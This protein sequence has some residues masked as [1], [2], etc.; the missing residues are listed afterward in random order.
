M[1]RHFLV[2]MSK[3]VYSEPFGDVPFIS[4]E[5]R[6]AANRKAAGGRGSTEPATRRD[7]QE[8]IAR[9]HKIAVT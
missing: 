9:P 1:L 3:P 4:Q 5:M 6:R 7:K 8:G 2:A